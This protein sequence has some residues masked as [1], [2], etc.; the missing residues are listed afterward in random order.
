MTVEDTISPRSVRRS[1]LIVPAGRQ[2]P[3]DKAP[4]LPADVVMYDL[5]DGVV[6]SEDEKVAARE[7]VVAAV[8]ARQGVQQVVVRTNALDTPWW[9][10]DVVAAAKAGADAVVP[11]KVRNPEDL[12]LIEEA[13]GISGRE[14]EIWPMIETPGAVLH[15]EQIAAI[16]SLV[17][18]LLFGVG[19]YTAEVQGEFDEA[20]DHLAYPLGKLICTARAAGL[21]AMAPAVSFSDM[22]RLD[23]IESQARYLRK[24]GFDGAMVMYPGHLDAVNDVF[25][26]SADEVAWAQRV[27]A[28]MRSASET[29]QSSVVIDG[30]LVELVNLT[31]AQ[32]IL[33]KAEKLGL[34]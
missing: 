19:D 25:T 15:C 20:I 14:V 27:D 23:V 16:S 13:V 34:A 12:R 10:D 33:A 9:R 2:R 31:A 32:K 5:D 21:A 28:E 29:G 11:A 4:S 22:S 26:P 24:L 3:V 8:A 17:R 6:F 7:R 18:V 1:L 30:R